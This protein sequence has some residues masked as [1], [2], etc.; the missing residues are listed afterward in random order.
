VRHEPGANQVEA[1]DGLEAL[2]GDVFGRRHVLPARVVHER[3]DTSV[4]LDHAVDE[5]A[6]LR[7]LADVAHDGL[8]LSLTK[9]CRLL[10]GLQ[11][12]P[13]DYDRGATCGQLK[14]RRAP[15]A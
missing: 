8:A 10:Q 4:T 9:R 14:S 7:F 1:H 11:A 12:A 15:E 6:H 3:V 13:R 2:Q 5:R